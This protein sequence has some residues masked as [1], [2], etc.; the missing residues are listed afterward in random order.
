M[1]RVHRA[2]IRTLLNQLGLYLQLID[3][4]VMHLLLVFIVMYVLLLTMIV[5]YPGVKY[6]YI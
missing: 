5:M 1:T 2:I 3:V 4:I 6:E